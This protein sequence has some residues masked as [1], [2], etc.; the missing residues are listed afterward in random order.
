MHRVQD[1]HGMGLIMECFDNSTS[2][3]FSSSIYSSFVGSSGPSA[4]YLVK[5]SVFRGQ[6]AANEM[7]LLWQ[8]WQWHIHLCM[9]GLSRKSGQILL[10][11]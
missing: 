6:A 3:L 5:L 2:H 9:F 1:G 4:C 7:L 11:A 10:H 8:Y